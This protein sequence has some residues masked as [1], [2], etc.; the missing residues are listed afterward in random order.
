MADIN[1]L[2]LTDDIIEVADVLPE[3]RGIR[4]PMLQPG[5][6]I[7]FQLPDKFD[8][9]P[10]ATDDGQRLMAKFRD[11]TAAKTF[12]GGVSI[13]TSVTNF[14]RTVKDEKGEEV[15]VNAF[16]YLLH[17]LGHT[18]VLRTN[19]DY[20]NALIQYGGHYFQSDWQWTAKCNAKRDVFMN[21][22]VVKG[23]SGCGQIYGDRTRTYKDRNGVLKTVLAFPKNSD[24]T[25]QE[26]FV[27]L[28]KRADG[29]V[30]GAQI[31]CNGE[32]TN[33]KPVKTED[34]AQ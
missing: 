11:A 27:C 30:C 29:S 20:A 24:G 28:G 13:R 17:A 32:W 9:E 33:F 6:A 26:S 10:I 4:L 15:R 21:G 23:R 16:A 12:P 7:I 2:Q 25:L 14:P 18:G 34:E 1:E 19:R 8:F 3:E 5:A 31:Y 22:A